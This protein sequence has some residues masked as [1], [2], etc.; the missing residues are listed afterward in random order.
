MTVRFHS[1]VVGSADAASLARFW[2]GLLEWQ[3]V[4]ENEEEVAIG[5]DDQT[6]PGLVFVPVDD[7]KAGRNRL[8]IDLAPDDRDA[9]VDRAVA[10]GARRV[11]VGQTA[12]AT[13][14]VLADP[15]GNEFCILS[16]RD[17]GL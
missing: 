12:E 9:E 17:A 4:F 5:R 1:V 14:V 2:A 7:T 10:L 15:E 13:W 3:V 6:Y 8:H 11:D 16:S